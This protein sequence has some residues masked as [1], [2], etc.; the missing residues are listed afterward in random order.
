MPSRAGDR[1]DVSAFLAGCS[2]A[3]A[4]LGV[5]WYLFGA[6][7]AFIYGAARLTVD[8]DITVALGERAPRELLAAL[9]RHDLRPRV[10]DED[11]VERTRVLPV[12]HAPTRIAGDIVLAGP[13]LEE[14]FLEHARVRDILGVPVPI[15]AAE[16]LVVM[17]VLA[18]RPK[19]IEDVKAIVAAQG[20]RLNV[21]RIRETLGLV[22][23]ALDQSDL[24]PAFESALAAVRSPRRRRKR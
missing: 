4:E 11:F 6:Q 9:S 20:D 2:A 17:K 22:E 13:G 7:A 14:M 1:P 5:R 12:V 16:D 3:F 24:L 10:A 19:D 18:G 8:V 21:D 23:G 15:A